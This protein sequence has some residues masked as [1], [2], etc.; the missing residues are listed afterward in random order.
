MKKNLLTFLIPLMFLFNGCNKEDFFGEIDL[1]GNGTPDMIQGRNTPTGYALYFFDG[2]LDTN[3]I[4]RGLK[5]KAI[6]PRAWDFENDGFPDVV[7]S[8]PGKKGFEDYFVNNKEGKFE[9][10]KRMKQ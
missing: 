1:N 6:N 7:Y 10:P 5:Y 2:S 8:F 4:A 9:K 3:Y